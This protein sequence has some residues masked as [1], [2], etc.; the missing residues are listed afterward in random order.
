MSAIIFEAFWD[1]L[2]LIPFLLVVY[3]AVATLEYRYGDAIGKHILKAGKAGPLLGAL[4]GGIPQCGFSVMGSALYAR[5]LVTV[6][7]LL[8]VFISTSD[9]AVPVILSRPDSIGWILPI[10]LTKVILAIA[11]G[12]G[13]DLALRTKPPDPDHHESDEALDSHGCCDHHIAGDCAQE[14]PRASTL[15]WHPLAHTARVF[16]FIFLVTLLIGFLNYRYEHVVMGRLFLQHSLL[17]PVIIALVGL[18]PNCAASVAITQLFLEH[19]ITFGS[20][21]AGLSTSAGVGLLVL[22]KENRNRRNTLFVLG[23]LLGVGIAVGLLLQILPL[24]GAPR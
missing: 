24:P 15:I 23:L 22:L 18:I 16:L 5:R 2:K 10:I 21:I 14:R 1:S 20:A 17:Q 9:E 3:V 19:S 6:G 11:V 8:A 7:T 12:Y 13:I 4:F